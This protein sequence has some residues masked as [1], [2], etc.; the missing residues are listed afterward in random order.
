M[1]RSKWKGQQTAAPTLAL[2]NALRL[3]HDYAWETVLWPTPEEEQEERRRT[4]KQHGDSRDRRMDDHRGGVGSEGSDGHG[5]GGGGKG[6]RGDPHHRRGVTAVGEA[7][8]ARFGR[9][10]A[11]VAAKGVA[12]DEVA[13]AVAAALE[14]ATGDSGTV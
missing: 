1:D 13:R 10:V 12:S 2:V 8:E 6:G 3:A 14:E 5:G 9:M 7:E 4:N 11:P